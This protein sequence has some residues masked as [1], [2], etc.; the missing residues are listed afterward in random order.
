ML[1][2]QATDIGRMASSIPGISSNSIR[3]TIDN[4]RFASF[5]LRRVSVDFSNQFNARFKRIQFENDLNAARGNIKT[6]NRLFESDRY[7][8]MNPGRYETATQ[9]ISAV[10]RLKELT[11]PF[12]SKMERYREIYG[13]DADIIQRAEADEAY[14]AHIKAVRDPIGASRDALKEKFGGGAR[15]NIL[16]IN[17]MRAEADEAYR[18]DM[19]S[20]FDSR[21]EDLTERYG[22]GASG[23]DK[24]YD[25]L[26]K[27]IPFLKPIAKN[28]P[29]AAKQLSTIAAHPAK[30]IGAGL[31]AL[32]VLD[33]K[34]VSASKSATKKEVIS[35]A[36]GTPSEELMNIVS[37]I[38][39]TDSIYQRRRKMMSTFGNADYGYKFIGETL[40]GKDD[41][42][43]E[44]LMQS[45]GID[46]VDAYIAMQM[47]TAP[48]DRVKSPAQK[49]ARAAEMVRLETEYGFSGHGGVGAFIQSVINSI[50]GMEALR[51][52]DYESFDYVQGAVDEKVKAYIE[53]TKQAGETANQSSSLPLQERV[54]PDSS[55]S[56]SGSQV[57]INIGT[58]DVNADNP[59]Q[60][61]Y[62]LG[63]VASSHSKNHTLA[64]AFDSGIKA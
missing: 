39:E 45:F 53:K 19:L 14:R 35:A 62:E 43:R 26:F 47:A 54:A 5:E 7:M 4:L 17:A 16:A 20:D 15:G 64:V 58:V 41:F 60:L 63:A 29:A 55:T 32:E 37:A 33:N 25:V 23:R 6:S 42:T 27:N 49:K 12:A 38:G 13:G 11:L 30:S 57:S 44:K 9:R 48:E 8:R 3:Q 21:M 40:K 36:V 34:I 24:A 59:E 10:D 51:R 61:A 1:R 56:Q 50:P 2:E 46:E 18:K 52:L 28:L 22:G 31:V